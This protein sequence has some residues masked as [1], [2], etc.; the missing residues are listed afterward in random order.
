MIN[1]FFLQ[2]VLGRLQLRILVATKRVTSTFRLAWAPVLPSRLLF[3]YGVC[4]ALP[5]TQTPGARV[6]T[7]LR[8]QLD[9]CMDRYGPPL[10][11]L[12]VFIFSLLP[13]LQFFGDLKILDP[14]SRQRAQTAESTE[15][16]STSSFLVHPSR[17]LFC[18]VG[19]PVAAGPSPL[20]W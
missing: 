17:L 16:N 7:V 4:F 20:K 6:Y 19:L 18:G 5:L 15:K 10:S 2:G 3:T 14:E 11:T 13:T 8:T 12:Y 9:S 1:I